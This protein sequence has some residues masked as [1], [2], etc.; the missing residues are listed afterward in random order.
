[1]KRCT[2]FALPWLLLSSYANAAVVTWHVTGAVTFVTNS[3]SGLLPFSNV[4]VGDPFVLEYTFDTATPNSGNPADNTEGDYR[5]L[6]SATLTIDG[7][8]THPPIIDGVFIVRDNYSS[9]NDFV[10]QYNL[11]TNFGGFAPT[12]VATEAIGMDLTNLSPTPANVVLSNALPVAPP[13]PALFNQNGNSFDYD[14]TLLDAQGPP[15]TTAAVGGHISDISV[16]PQPLAPSAL[17][18]E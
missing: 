11:K 3:A 13:N 10:D 5:A 15:G 7:V 9:G 8:T 1:M 14:V 17:R 4:V 12:G 18:A 6:T 16:A 2:A